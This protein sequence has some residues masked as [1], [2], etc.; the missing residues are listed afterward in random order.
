MGGNV[1]NSHKYPKTCLERWVQY[2]AFQ[3]RWGRGEGGRVQ[4]EEENVTLLLLTSYCF[5][6]KVISFIGEQGMQ[7]L[8]G[9]GRK[10]TERRHLENYCLCLLKRHPTF[11]RKQMD[12]RVLR[13]G[14]SGK[15]KEGGGKKRRNKGKKRKGQCPD[16]LRS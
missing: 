12:K 3:N 7:I 16:P 11:E 14:P 10:P 15:A 8:E 6:K 9:G 2:D 4:K 5:N 1:L 13:L